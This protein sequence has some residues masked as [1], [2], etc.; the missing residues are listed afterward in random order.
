MTDSTR[1]LTPAQVSDLI[2]DT[3]PYLSCDDCFDRLDVY[4]ERLLAGPGFAD[5]AMQAHL[6]GCGACAEEA[7]ALVALLRSES[8]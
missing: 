3:S 7:E 2:A 4:A 5:A 8:R 6:A 1:G